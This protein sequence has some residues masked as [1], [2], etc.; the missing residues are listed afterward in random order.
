MVRKKLEGPEITSIHRLV[1]DAVEVA[2]CFGFGQQPAYTLKKVT[3]IDLHRIPA[4]A[5]SGFWSE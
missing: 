5:G 1:Q 3:L 2:R 4:L